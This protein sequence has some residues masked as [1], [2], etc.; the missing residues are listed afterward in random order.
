MLLAVFEA[1]LLIIDD[2]HFPR[3]KAK[4][5]ALR[6]KHFMDTHYAELH[7]QRRIEQEC[8]VNINY[9]NIVFKKHTGTTLYRYLS[10]VRMEHAK[11][12]LE[13]TARPIVA[14]AE[15]VGYP[16]GN[17]FARAFRNLT[18]TSPGG[19]RRQHRRV[20]AAQR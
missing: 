4:S 9:L 17:T 19:Y 14:I 13:Q 20:G 1:G 18:G 12:M 8:G 3:D 5:L 6:A 16:D 11:H 7:H 2:E 15:E 10:Q